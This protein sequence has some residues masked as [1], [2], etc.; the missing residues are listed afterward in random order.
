MSV[1]PATQDYMNGKPKLLTLKKDT[2][3]NIKRQINQNIPQL[4]LTRPT[5]SII[6][7]D[8]H[9]F[10]SQEKYTSVFRPIFLVREFSLVSTASTADSGV[11]R[12]TLSPR[13]SNFYEWLGGFTDAEGYFYITIS[14]SCAFRF[15]I[16]LHKDDIDVLYYIHK[17]L[18]FG[19]V[20]SY[21]NFS[22]FT[23]TRLKDIALLIKIFDKY[24]LQGSKWLNYRDFS[25]AFEIYLNS[26]RGALSQP[27]KL[28]E[29]L[30]I[31]NGMN[32]LRS[33]F[34]MP[35]SKEIRITPYWLLGFIE[36]EGCFSINK[37]NNFRLDFSLCQ[38]S[39]NLELLQKIKIYLESLPSEGN[40]QVN[41]EGAFGIS[42]VRT[43]NP[44]HQPTTRI[45][46][47]RIPYIT[48]VFIPFLDS[49]TWRS[50][51]QL[52]FQDW[53]NILLLKE[54][55]HH[56]SEEGVKLIDLILSNMNNNRLSTASGHPTIDRTL[57]LAE[58]NLLL[59]KPSNFGLRNGK[60][61]VISLNKY[62][63]SSRTNVCVTIKDEEGNNL[64]SFDSL[65]DCAKFLVV[66]PSTVSKRII[67]GIPFWLENKLVYIKKEEVSN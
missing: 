33:D 29:I 17:T 53:K 56:L 30:N 3:S 54:Q 28:K 15:Q 58:I 9:C 2:C 47:A 62:Y 43:N 22:S 52:D 4:L 57:L 24:P 23:V 1:S 31:K 60:K 48:N 34:T 21:N 26:D 37:R 18:G 14:Q 36:G 19:E 39:T 50:K 8:L 20:R 10:T 44:N 42:M 5:L 35:N 16:N 66:H 64:H 55:G 32:R 59:T 11:E 67:K 45:E 61:W 25:K 7:P 46:T 12:E 49:L 38:S 51:K 41:S 13:M 27:Q 40:T 6:S 65:A 63:N